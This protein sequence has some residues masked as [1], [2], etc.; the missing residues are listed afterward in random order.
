MRAAISATCQVWGPWPTCTFSHVPPATPGGNIHASIVL[1][2]ELKHRE[3]G[4]LLEVTQQQVLRLDLNSCL[5]G[6]QVCPPD[7]MLCSKW[8]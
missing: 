1:R 3:V 2:R 5:P 6:P 7:H 8:G 4:R